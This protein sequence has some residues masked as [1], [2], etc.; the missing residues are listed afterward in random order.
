VVQIIFYGVLERGGG[1]EHPTCP[2]LRNPSEFRM[3]PGFAVKRGEI[4]VEP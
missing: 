4:L 2:A 1:P 3:L